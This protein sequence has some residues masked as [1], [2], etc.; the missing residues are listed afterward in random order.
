MKRTKRLIFLAA[1]LFFLYGCE[2]ALVGIGAGGGIAGYKY[3]EEHTSR[4]YPMEF[5]RAWDITNTALENLRISVVKSKS[6]DT[7]GMIKGIRKDGKDVIVKLKEN[8][9]RVTTISVRT[10]KLVGSQETAEMVLNEIAAVAG[11]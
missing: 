2:L 6:D 7:H 4:D 1:A 9:K 5:S 8:D 3:I 10:G 11:L